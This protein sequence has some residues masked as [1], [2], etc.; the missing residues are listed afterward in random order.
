MGEN[1][2]ARIPSLLSLRAFE[3]VARHGSFKSAAEE[4][5][6]T[7]G[8]LSQQVKKL[9]ADLGFFVFERKHRSVTLTEEGRQLQIALTT[10]F[11]GIE[12]S[13]SAL[14][15]YN[16]NHPI[17]VSCGAPVAAKW[18]APRLNKFSEI[19]PNIT[20]KVVSER[21][22]TNYQNQDIDIGIRLTRDEDPTLDR[23][24]LHEETAVAVCTPEYARKHKIKSPRDLKNVTLLLDD[25]L[26][27]CR[28]QIAEVWCQ[29]AELNFSEIKR[30]IHFGY[31]PEQALDA[32]LAGSGVMVVS[33][34][35]ASLDLMNNK[36][37][38]PFDIEVGTHVRYQIVT[39]KMKIKRSDVEAF[40][41][42]LIEELKPFEGTAVS[43]FLNAL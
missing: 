41:S 11:I 38:M 5:F 6:V 39:P 12:R 16:K 20:I 10:A 21:E 40:Q 28:G 4:I 24:W 35:L 32:A 23:V 7:P 34:T 8:A 15:V 13:I 26:N 25:G 37:I 42:W 33:K 2:S 36:L 27:Y 31:S 3:A 22:L 18:L 9:E 19:F 17:R 29:K 43:S 1:M 30:T 14:R